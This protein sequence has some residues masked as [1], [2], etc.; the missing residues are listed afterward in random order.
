VPILMGPFSGKGH[1]VST[2]DQKLTEI[3]T[4]HLRNEPELLFIPGGILS[5]RQ[6][7]RRT[8]GGRLER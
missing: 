2:Y 4:S 3:A 5:R 6:S 8:L 7:R 1:G